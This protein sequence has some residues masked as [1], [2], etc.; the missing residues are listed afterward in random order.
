MRLLFSHRY[1]WPD[2]PPYASIL[3]SVAEDLADAGHEVQVFA[4]RPSYRGIASAPAREILGALQVR[5]T[6]VFRENRANPV[7]RALNVLLYCGGL[8]IHILRTRPD[9]VIAATSPPIFAGWSASIAARL[10]GARFIYHMQ[11]IHPEVSK[12]SGGW[13]GHGIALR[14][15][16]WLDNQTLRRATG[17]VVLSEDMANTI[18]AR[19]IGDLPIHVIGNFLLESFDDAIP[20]PPELRK[21][22]GRKR[23]IFAGN[24]GR[25][26]NL[27]V[28]AEGVAG[29]FVRHP[30]LELFFLGDGAAL[31][32][33]KA[34]WGDNP[35]VRFAPFLPFCQARDLIA[36]SDV[37]LVSL[38]PNIY[39]VAY[40]S[41]VLSYLGLGIPVLAVVESDSMLAKL[42][43]DNG[44]GAV[45]RDLGPES[46][47]AALQ[48]IID[49]SGAHTNVRNWH[50]MHATR[51][52]ALRDWRAIISATRVSRV[53]TNGIRD[54]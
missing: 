15:L 27:P 36:E 13:L 54:K 2:T 10:V 37:G 24:L 8:I 40:P 29:C 14:L 19:G 5:R 11:D 50:R 46:I 45:P 53:Q 20:P 47:G 3:R 6:W 49:N 16:T 18:R 7:T 17:V 23:A 48:W 32:E 34:R 22:A 1:F 25:F 39:R 28:L 26:Q 51:E 31:P 44:I 21:A 30:E 33:L 35:Q 12:Y 42:I 52:V 4:S 41:K 43:R 38:A 9:L